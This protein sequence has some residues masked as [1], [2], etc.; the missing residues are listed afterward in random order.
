MEGAIQTCIERIVPPNYPSGKRFLLRFNLKR[1]EAKKK[2]FP[3]TT[4]SKSFWTNISKRPASA[5]SHVLLC[6]R[7]PWE[8][9]ASYRA[10]RCA[11]RRR[12][13]AQT[14]AQA[15]WIARPLFASLIACHRH[16]QFPRERRDSR[17]RSANRWPGRQSDHQTL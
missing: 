3:C 4:S 2:S 5:Q 15:S 16:H 11:H 12:G 1:K 6:F 7:P 10:D 8:R 17:G 9:P 13:H 14:T